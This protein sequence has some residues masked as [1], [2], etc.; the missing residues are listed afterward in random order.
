M[1]SNYALVLLAFWTFVCPYIL[2]GQQAEIPAYRDGEWWR[3][4][5]EVTRG[6]GVHVSGVCSEAYPEYL[7]RMDAGKRN[8]FGVKGDQLEPIDCPLIIARVLGEDDVKFP[9]RVGLAWSDRRSRQIP[10]SRPILT[11][12]Q[13]EVKSWEKIQT[14][15]GEFDAFKI[16]R[17]FF[18]SS[19]KGQ[20]RWQSET[21]FYAPALKAIVLYIIDEA[22]IKATTVLVDFNVTQ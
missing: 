17:S 12:Y 14:P 7:V 18:I 16:V 2:Y 6:G 22:P 15:K 4:K 3:I 20:G 8:A 19:P 10:G 9:M 1:K 21:Y 13:Y 11:D 5:R